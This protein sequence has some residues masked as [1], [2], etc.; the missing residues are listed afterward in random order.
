MEREKYRQRDPVLSAF[1]LAVQRQ[2]RELGISQEE[3]A[4]RIGIHRTYFAD[5]ERGTRNIGLLNIVAVAKG[6]ES[7]PSMLLKDIQ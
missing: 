5:V 6:L 7:T 2:R 4:E 1:G 3:A